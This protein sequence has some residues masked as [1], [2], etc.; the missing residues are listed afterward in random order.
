ME[1]IEHKFFKEL[2]K[3]L[4]TAADKL[5]SALDASVYK[6]VFSGPVFLKYVSDALEER[7]RELEEHWILAAATGNAA[8]ITAS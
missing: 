1:R 4:W 6:H 2:E 7:Q 3:K 5:R 8:D